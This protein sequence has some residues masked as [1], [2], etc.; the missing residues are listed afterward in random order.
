M[1]VI[2]TSYV[3]PQLH[4]PRWLHDKIFYATANKIHTFP[5][6]GQC[7]QIQLCM[8]PLTIRTWDACERDLSGKIA[9]CA[10]LYMSSETS[11]GTENMITSCVKWNRAYASPTAAAEQTNQNVLN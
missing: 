4:S 5:D 11:Q 1:S 10:F 8:I 3:Q 2:R 7:L 6:V 9:K